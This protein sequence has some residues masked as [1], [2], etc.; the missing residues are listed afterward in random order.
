VRKLIGRLMV[1]FAKYATVL[2]FL[3]IPIAHSGTLVPGDELFVRHMKD[4]TTLEG[5]RSFRAVIDNKQLQ[6]YEG[7]NFFFFMSMTFSPLAASLI[8]GDNICGE[9]FHR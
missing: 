3:V 4:N 5:K 2:F 6:D 9:I 7:S 8:S 1:V